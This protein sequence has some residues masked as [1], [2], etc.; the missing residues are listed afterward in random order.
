MSGMSFRERFKKW[1]ARN[2][3][4][5]TLGTLLL[6]LALAYLYPRIVISIH[7]GQVGV[8][9]SRFFGG[10]ITEKYYDEGIHFIVPWNVMYVYDKRLQRKSSTYEILTSDGLHVAVEIA[11]RFR[12]IE[13]HAG[14]LHKY[15][16][17]DYVERLLLP[18]IGSHASIEIAKYRPDQL[19]SVDRERIQ[20][21]ILSE[22]RGEMPVGYLPEG[23]ARDFLYI[24]DVLIRRITLPDVI[25]EAIGRKLEEEQLSLEFDY[26]LAVAEKERQRKEIEAMGIRQFQDIVAEGISEHY[27]KWKGIEATLRLAESDNAKIVVIGAGDDGLPIILGP[28]DSG[29]ETERAPEIS[30]TPPR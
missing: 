10:T 5:L 27:L 12:V 16:G 19:Y 3:L 30:I 8:Q 15:V 1:V 29:S 23:E 20:A 25:R 28:L 26:R 21:V 9:W 6:V 18:E 7:S 4:R 17:P 13:S 14:T 22:L 2:E 24:Q 11:V